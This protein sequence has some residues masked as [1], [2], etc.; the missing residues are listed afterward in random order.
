M[1][2]W[3]FED[4]VTSELLTFSRNPRMMDSPVSQSVSAVDRGP[5]GIMRVSRPPSTAF[6]WSFSGRVHTK[7][8]QDTLRDWAG[9]ERIVVRDHLGREHVVIPQGLEATPV[10]ARSNGTR[11]PWLYEYV[12]KTIYLRRQS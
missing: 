7:A 10:A 1:M 9:R 5:T 11:N 8:E 6:P 3:R 2:R 12:F 4:D